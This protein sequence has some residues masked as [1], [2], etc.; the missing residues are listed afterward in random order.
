MNN[1]QRI[2]VIEAY[3]D[4]FYSINRSIPKKHYMYS[5][6]VDINLSFVNDDFYIDRGFYSGGM[7]TFTEIE[8]YMS[9]TEKVFYRHLVNVATEI[10]SIVVVSTEQNFLLKD[11]YSIDM[12]EEDIVKIEC[13]EL[14]IGEC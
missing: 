8:L 5:E 3:N 14:R 9:Q 6:Y 13:R 10:E 4:L 2:D 7:N 11:I 1:I 12:S